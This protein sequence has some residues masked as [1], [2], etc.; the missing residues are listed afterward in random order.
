VETFCQE[1]NRNRRVEKFEEIAPKARSREKWNRRWDTARWYNTLNPY[2]LRGE[3]GSW[4]QA[5]FLA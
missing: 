3:A 5:G 2:S 1:R 4:L